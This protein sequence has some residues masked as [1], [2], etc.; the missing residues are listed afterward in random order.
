MNWGGR[1]KESTVNS[2]QPTVY[3]RQS[4]R[5]EEK[6]REENSCQNDTEWVI[7]ASV[8]MQHYSKLRVWERSHRL[9]LELYQVTQAFP[10]AER[11]GLTSQLRRAAVSVPTNIAEGSK[12]TSHKDFA[13]FLNIA[14]GSLAETE[15]LILVSRD[16]GLI[17]APLASK[18]LSE[19][20]ELLRMLHGLR[21]TIQKES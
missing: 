18:Q 13:H 8:S 14:E 7:S 20:A 15:Y 11:Y 21:V 3:S 16:L 2:L 17:P 1:G 19:V 6:R 5:R 4:K 10:V 12:R 9:V